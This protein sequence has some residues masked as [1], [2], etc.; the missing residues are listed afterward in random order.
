VL[1]A[2]NNEGADIVFV[3]VGVVEVLEQALDVLKKGGTYILFA[4]CPEGTKITI[5]PNTVHYKEILFTGASAST[6]D[7]Q[8]KVL[9]LVSSGELDVRPLITDV[10]PLEDWERALRMKAGHKGLKSLLR[11]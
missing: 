8:R 11:I 1:N 9:E 5:D 6:P 4:G 2:T 7:Y 10:M 3:D